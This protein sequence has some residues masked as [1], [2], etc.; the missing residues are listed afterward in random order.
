MT[1]EMPKQTSPFLFTPSTSHAA[2]TDGEGGITALEGQRQQGEEKEGEEKE[3]EEEYCLCHI[4]ILTP[5]HPRPLLHLPLSL[6]LLQDLS[7][8]LAF[9]SVPAT[10]SNAGDGARLQELI[11]LSLNVFQHQFHLGI[12]NLSFLCFIFF[13]IYSFCT[14]F[15]LELTICHL[16][17][18]LFRYESF[19]YLCYFSIVS[20][21]S[22]Y[23]LKLP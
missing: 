23:Q 2:P 22:I 7:Q 11:T 6:S 16:F 12:S 5:T 21:L 15:Q 17:I 19:N 13:S 3:E 10:V 18:Y 14:I 8:L 1:K 9:H 4:R 20:F